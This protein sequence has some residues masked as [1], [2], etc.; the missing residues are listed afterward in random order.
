MTLLRYCFAAALMLANL[1]SAELVIE[2]TEGQ[3]DPTPIAVVP[4]E[5]TGKGTLPEDIP[6]IIA[7]DLQRVGQFDPIERESMLGMP[8]NY[9]DV[10]FRDWRAIGSEY[11]VIG[12]I[13]QETVDGPFA[14]E[15]ELVDIYRQRRLLKRRVR[16]NLK[17]FRDMAHKISDEVYEKLTGLPGAFSTRIL[18]VAAN[19]TGPGE[20]NYRLMMADADG[21]RERLIIER[22]EPI[23]SPTWA[24]NAREIAYVSFETTK[25]AIYRHELATGRRDKLTGFPGLNSAPSWSPDGKRMAMVLSKDGSPD[26]YVMDLASKKLTKVAPHYA[27]DTEPSWSPDGKSIIFTSDRG[28][29]PQIYQVTLAS[30]WVERLTFDGTY[31]ARARLLPER[32][33]LVMIHRR[34]GDRNFHVAVQS[35][36]SGRIHILS[37]TFLDESPTVA[38]NG[39]MLMYATQYRNKGILAAVSVDGSVKFR[40]PSSSS[41]VREPAWSPYL[42]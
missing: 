35:L 7:A 20:F 21:A 2:I 36:K 10:F 26:I 31:N 23:L 24:P 13:S 27:I 15:Y 16:G 5:W 30:G 12:T 28:G 34:E 17:Q 25:P 33:A 19:N 8:S 32:N 22:T 42:N 6:A 29:R 11:L 3:D 37:Q 9:E 18:Y 1:A 40:L 39:A 38:P 41:D 14:V 4:F